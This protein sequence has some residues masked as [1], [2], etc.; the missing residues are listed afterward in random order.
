MANMNDNYKPY[1]VE[2]QYL[3]I[4]FVLWLADVVRW[5]CKIKYI[6]KD[7][8]IRRKLKGKEF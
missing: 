5:C 2:R 3:I 1:P 7:Y 6:V 4:R 8:S